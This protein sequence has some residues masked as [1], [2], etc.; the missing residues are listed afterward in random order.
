MAASERIVSLSRRDYEDFLASLAE[1]FRPNEAL[2]HALIQVGA[3][4]QRV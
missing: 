2:S 1:P 3:R 4:V